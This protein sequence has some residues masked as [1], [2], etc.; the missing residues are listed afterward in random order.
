[1]TFECSG[2]CKI[3]KFESQYITDNLSTIEY[4]TFFWEKCGAPH[5]F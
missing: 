5:I 1:M 4:I 2:I 3:W